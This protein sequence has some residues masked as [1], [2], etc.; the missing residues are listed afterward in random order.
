ML[1]Q[2]RC[3]RWCFCR[4]CLPLFCRSACLC[5]VWLIIIEKYCLRYFISRAAGSVFAWEV[6]IIRDLMAVNFF[7]GCLFNDW[8]VHSNWF[9]PIFFYSWHKQHRQL[10]FAAVVPEGPQHWQVPRC[11]RGGLHE[12]LAQRPCSVC[13]YSLIPARHHVSSKNVYVMRNKW[14]EVLYFSFVHL[15][16]FKKKFFLCWSVFWIGISAFQ[17]F[18]KRS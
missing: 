8:S 9:C 7:V 11:S 13:P 3:E 14:S 15:Y 10:H 12:F 5:P 1:L 16:F 6:F 4:I 17:W 2:D 18:F